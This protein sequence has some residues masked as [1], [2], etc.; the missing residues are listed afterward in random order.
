MKRDPPAR[1]RAAPAMN[2]IASETLN[3]RHG[4]AS[5]A[6]PVWLPVWLDK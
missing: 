3:F 4:F 2:A 6:G 5:A 1:M